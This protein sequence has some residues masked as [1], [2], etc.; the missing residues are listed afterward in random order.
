MRS[1]ILELIERD[2]EA[3]DYGGQVRQCSLCRRVQ[4]IEAFQTDSTPGKRYGRD[5]E[6]KVC[7]RERTYLQQLEGVPRR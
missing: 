4:P 5:Q 1:P 3:H 6:C 2:R 7:N